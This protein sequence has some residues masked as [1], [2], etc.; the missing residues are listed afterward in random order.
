MKQYNEELLLS[1]RPRTNTNTNCTHSIF[2]KHAW[3]FS[4]TVKKKESKITH[5]TSRFS[6]CS[7]SCGRVIEWTLIELRFNIRI[8]CDYSL[9]NGFVDMPSSK[10]FD[11]CGILSTPASDVLHCASLTAHNN[12]ASVKRACEVTL[13]KWSWLKRNVIAI[14]ACDCF[15]PRWDSMWWECA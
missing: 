4:E 8:Y 13:L 6:L 3:A 2:R 7:A 12:M 9:F 10:A 1:Y 5:T 11:T 14:F 15:L